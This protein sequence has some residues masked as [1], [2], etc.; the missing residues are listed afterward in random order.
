RDPTRLFRQ[1]LH[2]RDAGGAG[3]VPAGNVLLKS[4]A[5]DT[6]LKG[7][8]FLI[9]VREA[10]RGSEAGEM[11]ACTQG[12]Q[13]PGW[14]SPRPA[15]GFCSRLSSRHLRPGDKLFPPARQFPSASKTV[16]AN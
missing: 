11:W 1:T 7:G 16:A 12:G 15:A 14:A 13:R 6:D 5:K 2:P 8:L 9:A 4:G 3:I 10:A